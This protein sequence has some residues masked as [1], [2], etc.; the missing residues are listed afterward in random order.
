MRLVMIVSK[1]SMS[2]SSFPVESCVGFMGS[3]ELLG[4]SSNLIGNCLT[5]SLI[6]SWTSWL[7]AKG[8]IRG[9]YFKI[10]ERA[11][12]RFSSFEVILRRTISDASKIPISS[13]SY[14]ELSRLELV[15]GT[16]TWHSGVKA[17]KKIRPSEASP[18]SSAIAWKPTRGAYGVSR[19]IV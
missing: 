15:T 3:L 5:R 13:N 1:F 17:S 7:V 19:I 10:V 4:L 18:S 8:W 14:Q 6:L 12:A 9:S 16:T 2:L 11:S